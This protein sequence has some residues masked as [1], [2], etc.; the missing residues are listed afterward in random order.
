MLSPSQNPT[1]TAV[2]TRSLYGRLVSGLLAVLVAAA[3]L[4]GTASTANAGT[5]GLRVV[6]WEHLLVDPV[7]WNRFALYKKCKDRPGAQKFDYRTSWIYTHYKCTD[8]V[9][10]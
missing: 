6:A 10:R 3:T 9:N 8:I 7:A 4:I 1:V 2:R 5:P